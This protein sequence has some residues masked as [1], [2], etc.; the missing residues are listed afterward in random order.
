MHT[1][2]SP[3]LLIDVESIE[4]VANIQ[5]SLLSLRVLVTIHSKDRDR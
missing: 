5:K 4:T 1:P 2:V 3:Y